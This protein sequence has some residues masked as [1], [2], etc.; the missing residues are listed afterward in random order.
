MFEDNKC[1]K[2]KLL[3][4]EYNCKKEVFSNRSNEDGRFY[5]TTVCPLGILTWIINCKVID[6]F[7]IIGLYIAYCLLVTTTIGNCECER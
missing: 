3:C 6:V 5:D 4:H 7:S 1:E 2:Q